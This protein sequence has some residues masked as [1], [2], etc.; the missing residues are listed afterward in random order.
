MY[1][2]AL[3]VLSEDCIIIG[4]E[5]SMAG[6]DFAYFAKKVPSVYFYLGSGNEKRGI[7]QPLHSKNFDIDEGCL[8]VGISVMASY[9]VS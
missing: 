7:T 6:D 5:P 8:S 2:A 3:N 9:V 1:N 4:N